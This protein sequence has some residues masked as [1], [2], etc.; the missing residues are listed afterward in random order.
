MVMFKSYFHCVSEFFA[1]GSVGHPY[2]KTRVVRGNPAG[3][4]NEVINREIKYFASISAAY[5]CLTGF[6]VY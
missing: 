1:T 4:T 6:S 5:N 3:H 2:L